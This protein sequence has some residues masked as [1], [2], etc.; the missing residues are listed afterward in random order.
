MCLKMA[1]I[2]PRDENKQSVVLNAGIECALFVN[3]F[4]SLSFT[5]SDI[6]MLKVKVANDLQ[7]S[8]RLAL[9]F[10]SFCCL[11]KIDPPPPN[12]S[13]T[14]PVGT[15]FGKRV[16]EMSL[17]NSLRRRAQG[18]E[19]MWRRRWREGEMEKRKGQRQG[20]DE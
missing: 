9:H 8:L 17:I 4:F 2:I 14:G 1:F 6:N 20:V 3:R 5:H 12:H 10:S 18:R 16:P 19:E 15:G 7:L 11:L 13:A